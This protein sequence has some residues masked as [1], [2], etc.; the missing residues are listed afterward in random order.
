MH[1]NYYFTTFKSTHDAIAFYK[2]IT[3]DG[4]NAIIM[5]VPR[6]I[7]ASCG[8]SIR[9]NTEDLD[10]LKEFVKEEGLMVES[11]YLVERENKT[12]NK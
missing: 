10:R 3:Q 11:Y 2:R 7:S 6:E 5:P 12:D 9:F 1:S 8:L 4:Y